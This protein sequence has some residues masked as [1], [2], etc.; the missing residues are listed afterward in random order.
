M[1]NDVINSIIEAEKKAEEI[2]HEAGNKS[3]EILA[4]SDSERLD[5]FRAAKEKTKSAVKDILEAGEKEASE[6]AAEIIEKGKADAEKLI[7]SGSSG[8]AEAKEYI[9]RRI[10]SKYGNS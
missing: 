6:A 8:S 7:K 4:Y 9:V 3:K 10:F 1:V 5:I 2:L